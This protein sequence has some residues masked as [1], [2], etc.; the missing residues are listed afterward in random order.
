MEEGGAG[1]RKN[2]DLLAQTC[3]RTFEVSAYIQS[4]IFMPVALSSCKQSR[5]YGSVDCRI[6]SSSI[7]HSRYLT[8]EDGFFTDYAF[9]LYKYKHAVRRHSKMVA[10]ATVWRK[11]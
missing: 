4:T 1:E 7:R 6:I 10:T 5:S 8:R 2:N 9:Y 11:Q 3:T